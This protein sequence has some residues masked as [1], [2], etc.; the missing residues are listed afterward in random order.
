MVVKILFYDKIIKFELTS[1]VFMTI[2]IATRLV[3]NIN[4][5]SDTIELMYS[6]GKSRF[7]LLGGLSP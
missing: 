4:N 6:R 2:L 7:P 3:K 5:T 1:Y